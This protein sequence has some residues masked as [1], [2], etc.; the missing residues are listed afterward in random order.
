MVR[1]VWWCGV[2]VVCG[3]EGGCGVGVRWVGEVGV[4]WG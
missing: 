3:G 2:G 1:W 4:V